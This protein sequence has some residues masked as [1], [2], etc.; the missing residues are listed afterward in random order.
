MSFGR[1][2]RKNSGVCQAE[3]GER[4]DAWCRTGTVASSSLGLPVRFHEDLIEQA[5]TSTVERTHQRELHWFSDGWQGY[6]SILVRAIASGC[7]RAN[8]DVLGGWSQR[9]SA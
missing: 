8:G 4:W 1:S 2:C 3:A 9:W 7:L 6:R 5:V